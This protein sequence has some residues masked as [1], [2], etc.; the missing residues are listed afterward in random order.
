MT[1][2]RFIASLFFIAALLGQDV[3]PPSIPAPGENKLPPNTRVIEGIVVDA[4]G[5]PAPNAVVLL[6]DT[7]TLQIRSFVAQTDGKYHFYGLNTDV[8]YQVRAHNNA[9]TSPWKLIS[10]FN[11]RKRVTVVLKLKNK[12]EAKKG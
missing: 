8:N 11:S 9:M 5:A 12:I 7:K 4:K 3:G 10:V 6:R 1:F 2:A